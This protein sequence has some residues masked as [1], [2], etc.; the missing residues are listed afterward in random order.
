MYVYNNLS[1]P[2]LTAKNL[3]YVK[4]KIHRQNNKKPP[5]WQQDENLGSRY[6]GCSFMS[7]FC[8]VRPAKWRPSLFQ[9]L[10]RVD[11]KNTCVSSIL[12]GLYNRVIFE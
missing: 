1:H 5:S 4:M 2:F 11:S 10:V 8:L 6:L 12:G 3:V 9:F 7:K